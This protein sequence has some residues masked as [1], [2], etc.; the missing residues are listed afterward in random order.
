MNASPYETLGLDEDCT[1]EEIKAAYRELVKSSHPDAGGDGDWHSIRDAY[2]LLR[3]PIRRDRYDSGEE[4]TSGADVPAALVES[5]FER[6]V[7]HDIKRDV[8]EALVKDLTDMLASTRIQLKEQQFQLTKTIDL[9]DRI[10]FTGRGDS[11]GILGAVID[12]RARQIE[13]A[14]ANHEQSI[15]QIEEAIEIARQFDDTWEPEQEA[16]D[17][18]P[19][20]YYDIG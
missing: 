2:E 17:G 19:L 11:R 4:D 9:F 12:A 1:E 13:I 7:S 14:I 10:E 3:D 8:C 5:C 15:E 6:I 16:L 18:D 20:S